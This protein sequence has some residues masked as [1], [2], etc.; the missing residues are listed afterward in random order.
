M[1]IYQL[2]AVI[3]ASLLLFLV[4]KGVNER[5]AV[6]L[7][8][9]GAVIILLY[10]IARLSSVF[11]FIR[12]LAASAGVEN[13]YFQAVLKGL[14]ICYLGEFVIGICKDCG[15]SGWGD[16]LEVACRCTLLVVAIPLFEDFLE[17]IM[18]LLE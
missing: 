18:G 5:F 11:S 2:L 15:Q 7:S 3:I 6:Y 4:I 12:H 10:V 1:S 17:I 14:A 13:E 8:L 9:G 16:K